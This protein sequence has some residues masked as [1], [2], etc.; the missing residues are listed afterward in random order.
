MNAD[1][2]DFK[3]EELIK[4]S[5]DIGEN[6]RPNLI[7]TAHRT[8]RLRQLLSPDRRILPSTPPGR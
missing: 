2:Q 8:K 7:T 1:S 3:Y 4:Q 5:A 6:L